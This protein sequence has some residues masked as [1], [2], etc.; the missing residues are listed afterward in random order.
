MN[1]CFKGEMRVPVNRAHVKHLGRTWIVDD[2]L[3]LS[4]SGSGIEFEYEGKGLTLTFVGGIRTEQSTKYFCSRMGVYIDGERVIDHMIT[5][6]E[7][8]LRIAGSP[9][10]KKSVVRIVKLSECQISLAGIKALDVGEDE[11]VRPTPAKAH[12]IEFI[13]DSLTCGFGVDDENPVHL[14]QTETEDVTKSFAYK[15]AEALDVDYS[16]FSL[17]GFGIVSGGTT[18]RKKVKVLIPDYYEFMGTCHGDAFPGQPGIEKISWDF[19]LFQPDA[20]VINAGTNDYSYCRT[21]SEL[22]QEFRD[23]YTAFLKMVRRNN[24]A[25]KIF[26]IMGMAGAELFPRICEAVQ[27]YVAETKDDNITTLR[28]SRP[29]GF[30]G[31]AERHPTAAA[32]T[33]TAGELI[34]FIRSTMGW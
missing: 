13:G 21:R 12:K 14:F 2:V 32:H 30:K 8:T 20:V 1:E 24:P 10:K 5:E 31:A 7:M 19:S 26:C 4:L 11:S 33:E 22:Q 27:N 15:T 23:G 6:K 16:M 3:Y 34:P 29:P 28:L 17:S 9:T 18:P 25:A